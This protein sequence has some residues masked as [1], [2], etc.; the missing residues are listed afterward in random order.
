MSDILNELNDI[1]NEVKDQDQ[2]FEKLPDGE[3]LCIIE[4][5]IQKDS[6]AGNPG[7]LATL[8]IT[9]GEHANKKIWK[10]FNL[11]GKDEKQLRN[12]LQRYA[13]EIRKLGVS[14]DRGLNGTFDQFPALEG[15][16]VVAKIKTSKGY[17]N[18]TIELA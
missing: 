7:V 10:W 8:S 14:T 15:M 2:E 17:T 12:N 9:Y 1:F 3:Y 13:L 18:T 16:E 4:D 6:K 11:T 5:I